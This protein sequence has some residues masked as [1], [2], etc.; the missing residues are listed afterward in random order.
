[1]KYKSTHYRPLHAFFK[2]KDVK[3]Q[4]D[5]VRYH[6]ELGAWA[7]IVLPYISELSVTGRE[8]DYRKNMCHAAMETEP[9]NGTQKDLKIPV[10]LRKGL[11]FKLFTT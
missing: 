2:I 8:E 4:F 10:D 7:T 9:M 5:S 1:M 11:S 3:E 6:T